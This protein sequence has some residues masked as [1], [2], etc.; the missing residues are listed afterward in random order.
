MSDP[1]RVVTFPNDR[2]I[3]YLHAHEGD[4]ALDFHGRFKKEGGFLDDTQNPNWRLIG[5]ARG[6]VNVPANRKILPRQR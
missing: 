5:E 4:G 1:D 2:L 3:G 6:D